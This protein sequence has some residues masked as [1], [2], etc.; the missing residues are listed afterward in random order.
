MRVKQTQQRESSKL[1]KE[2][3]KLSKES[4][5]NSSRRAKQTQQCI[6]AIESGKPDPPYSFLPVFLSAFLTS[7]GL[8][9]QMYVLREKAM[10]SQARYG[11]NS[12]PASGTFT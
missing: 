9:H 3:S 8:N 1:I 10:P 4:Q 6:Y 12:K 5:A 2:P 11:S 7:F